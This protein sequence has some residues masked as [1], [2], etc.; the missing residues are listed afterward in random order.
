MVILAAVILMI[1]MVGL[2]LGVAWLIHLFTEP[3]LFDYVTR[4]RFVAAFT[5]A[6]SIYLLVLGCEVW[7]S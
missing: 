7:E 6:L 3:W 5:I 1:G 2:T 4:S